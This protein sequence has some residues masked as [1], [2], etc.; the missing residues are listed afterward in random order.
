MDYRVS[1]RSEQD[2]IPAGTHYA[3]ALI[4]RKCELVLLY[5]PLY[6]NKK[7]NCGNDL[8]LAQYITPVVIPWTSQTF[9]VNDSAYSIR[10][11]AGEI[12]QHIC[13][14]THTE[15]DAREFLKLLGVITHTDTD[16]PNGRIWTKEEI[17]N[18][19]AEYDAIMGLT[20]E[21]IP[22]IAKYAE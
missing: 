22:D 19:L 12:Y 18:T 17:L 9:I 4:T 5:V 7:P 1:H 14:A 10:V 15:Y 21:Q 6:E 2:G 16:F 3:G 13:D 20:P 11:T 8:L